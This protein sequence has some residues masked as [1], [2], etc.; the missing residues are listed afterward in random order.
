ME[1]I[2][3]DY[4]TQFYGLDNSDALDYV[5][6]LFEPGE[7]SETAPLQPRHNRYTEER[8]G[9]DQRSTGPAQGFNVKG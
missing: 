3:I 8:G 9:S 7:M 2:Q 1:Q 4:Y 5:L 6:W